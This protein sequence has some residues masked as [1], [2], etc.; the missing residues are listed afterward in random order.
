M[1]VT[2]TVDKFGLDSGVSSFAEKIHSARSLHAIVGDRHEIH[3][4]Q[5]ED[6]RA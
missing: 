4:M 1:P 2:L 6:S 5:E 3:Q